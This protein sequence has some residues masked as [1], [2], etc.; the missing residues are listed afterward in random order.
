MSWRGNAPAKHNQSG[1]WPDTHQPFRSLVP[2]WVLCPFGTVRMSG[3]TLPSPHFR[4]V[5]KQF[6]E[7]SPSTTN[8]ISK[9]IK[10]FRS[11]SYFDFPKKCLYWFRYTTA[12]FENGSCRNQL[13]FLKWN[14]E[15][16]KDDE[17]SVFKAPEKWTWAHSR[18]SCRNSIGNLSLG[19][20]LGNEI[21]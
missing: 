12:W 1:R 15:W 20:L 14:F 8:K 2:H 19:L 11:N 13:G 10:V 4:N 6:F 7:H 18:N 9:K 16:R 5:A 17:A 21:L 3:V